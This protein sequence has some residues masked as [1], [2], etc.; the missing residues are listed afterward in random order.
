[1]HHLLLRNLLKIENALGEKLAVVI[2]FMV[3]FFT[4]VLLAF[5]KG[6]KLTLVCLV[7]LPLTT[8]ALILIT[9][10]IIAIEME[11]FSFF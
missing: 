4:C 6:W 1:M 3:S 7:G 11:N 5:F 10:V 9:A 8:F 2:Y